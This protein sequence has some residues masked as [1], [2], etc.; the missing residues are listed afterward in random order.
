MTGWAAQPPEFSRRDVVGLTWWDPT[1]E[2]ARCFDSF[3]P[4]AEFHSTMV[5]LQRGHGRAAWRA[6][7][8]WSVAA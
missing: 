7:S 8:T 6:W 1:A 2:R 4:R 3:L 5:G